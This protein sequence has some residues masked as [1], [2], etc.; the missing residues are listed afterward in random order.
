MIEPGSLR[1]ITV[2]LAGREARKRAHQYIREF[3]K[4]A[5]VACY[6]VTIY[7]G[8]ANVA[9]H[10]LRPECRS[11]FDCRGARSHDHYFVPS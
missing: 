5:K 3:R 1:P 10:N 2:K 4:R 6:F 7:S 9:K 11:Y 8:Q